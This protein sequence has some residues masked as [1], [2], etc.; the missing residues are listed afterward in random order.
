MR[1]ISF[2]R[3]TGTRTDGIKLVSGDGALPPNWHR[4]NSAEGAYFW[5]DQ[6]KEVGILLL[7]C[8]LARRA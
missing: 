1:G 3:Q 5:N 6:T 2:S 4:A 8:P 7:C